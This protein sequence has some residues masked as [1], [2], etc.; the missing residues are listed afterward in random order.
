MQ[1]TQHMSSI[2]K[3]LVGHQQLPNLAVMSSITSLH[4]AKEQESTVQAPI[5]RECT[6]RLCNMTTCRD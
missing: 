5:Q 1:T 2:N 6:Q 4:T 3:R